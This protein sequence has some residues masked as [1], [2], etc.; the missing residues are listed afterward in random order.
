[1]PP[2][3][4]PKTTD[5]QTPKSKPPWNTPKSDVE[6]GHN[7]ASPPM[8]FEEGK[9]S[10]IC[11][12]VTKLPDFWQDEPEAWFERVEAMFDLANIT[13]D[14]TRY[15]YILAHA[16][17]ELIPYIV[18]I[19][20]T[21]LPD[22]ESSYTIFKKRVVQGFACS[23]EAKL[24][25]LF[26]AQF[27][28]DSKPSQLLLQLR[29]VSS[30]QCSDTV[31]RSLFLER[32]P[33][34]VKIILAVSSSVT[35]DDLALLADKIM[36]NQSSSVDLN[37]IKSNDLYEIIKELQDKVSFLSVQ[38]KKLTFADN[39]T[40]RFRTRSTSRN[41]GNANIKSTHDHR[42]TGSVKSPMT[43]GDSSTCWYHKKFGPRAKWCK[44]PCSYQTDVHQEN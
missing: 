25:S 42:T 7:S 4:K 11:A 30:G 19:R 21:P 31:L 8:D 23:E 38:I 35:L 6:D 10:S 37:E 18:G 39:T 33:E 27:L 12:Q 9:V 24:G 28:G 40:N 1:M 16:S 13:C 26:K 34:K 3:T 2:K 20:N 5:S 44:E 43:E 32:L 22:G 14:E 29:N 17:R 15:K 41:R 36:E